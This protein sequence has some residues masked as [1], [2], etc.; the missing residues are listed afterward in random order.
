MK[1]PSLPNDI[2]EI[3]KERVRKAGEDDREREHSATF[4]RIE[5]R[6]D[7]IRLASGDAEAVVC[8]AE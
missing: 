4:S 3:K 1:L 5:N 2:H 7:P 8:D 6:H